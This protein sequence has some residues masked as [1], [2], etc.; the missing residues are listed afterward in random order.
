[1]AI[2]VSE[3]E[4]NYKY[5]VG[6]LREFCN[7][8]CMDH[9]DNVYDRDQYDE[10]IDNEIVELLYH[11]HWERVK[12]WLND[13][14]ESYNGNYYYNDGYDWFSITDDDTDLWYDYVL[15][16]ALEHGYVIEDEEEEDEDDEPETDSGQKVYKVQNDNEVDEDFMSI[17]NLEV[18]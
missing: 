12:E 7:E 8:N 1:M 3:F 14:P 15:E 10:A 17:L 18:A 9:M 11:R 13:L 6:E 4:E 5:D 2:T 16:Y